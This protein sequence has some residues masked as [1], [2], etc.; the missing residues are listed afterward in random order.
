[1]RKTVIFVLV[2]V[3]LFAGIGTQARKLETPLILPP[4]IEREIFSEHGVPNGMPC[5]WYTY[6]LNHGLDGC[7]HPGVDIEAYWEPV[8]AATDGIVEFAD[9]SEYYEPAY[10][11][12]RA[13]DA[14]Y[15]GE[16]HIYGHLSEFF[17]TAGQEVQ[18]GDL[19][20]ISGTA[21]S[22]PH[23]HFE[24]RGPPTETFPLGEGLDPTDIV[25]DLIYEKEPKVEKSTLNRDCRDGSAAGELPAVA[26]RNE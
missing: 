16:E 7:S 10:V 25:I 9:W 5:E 3:F 2:L 26:C 19:L 17:V 22:G 13:Q 11:S 4:D 14:V 15:G 8:Y 18:R 1:M 20:G 21:G 12:L 24:R 23:L 6:G